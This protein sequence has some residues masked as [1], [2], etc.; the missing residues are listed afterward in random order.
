MVQT[1]R[2]EHRSWCLSKSRT[3]ILQSLPLRESLF[4]TI[5]SCRTQ[6]QPPRCRQSSL[7]CRPLRSGNCVIS[8]RHLFLVSFFL[9]SPVYCSSDDATAIYVD[10]NTRIQILESVNYLP[11]A[12]KEQCGA[13]IVS[14]FLYIF[15]LHFEL[16]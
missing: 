16:K 7:G 2:G 5:R 4:G 14:F 11:K 6:S 3:R 12:D 8:H 9:F 10:V 1:F 15:K 13:F